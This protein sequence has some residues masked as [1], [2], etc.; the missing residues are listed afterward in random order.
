[1]EKKE[2]Y[3]HILPHFQQPGQAYFV[4]WNLQDAVPPK[5]L[6]WYTH[7]LET[8]KLQ[9]D[10]TTSQS[11][12]NIK[13]EAEI[14]SHIEKLKQEYILVRKK[15]IKAYDD[16]LDLDKNP[17]IDL[18]QSVNT[19]IIIQSLQ[20][21]EGKRLKNIAFTIMPNHVHWVF[22]L[23]E[24]DSE[25]KPVYLQDV[26]QS[27]KRFSSYQINKS[28]KR[29]GKLW[30]KESY[31]TTIRDETHLYYAIKYT[32]NNPVKAGLVSDWHDWKGSWT[33]SSD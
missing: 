27:V 5:A 19:A 21:W 16:L 15:Y 24:K 26:L 28:E 12:D 33:G 2:S 4:T 25:G 17:A 6:V 3:R 1:M 23:F 31:D 10:S 22:E 13:C 14:A 32:L 29:E 7:Q 30:Q 20:F 18:A 9:M 8:L 11:R